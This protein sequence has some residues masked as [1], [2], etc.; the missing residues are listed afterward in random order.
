MYPSRSHFRCHPS[1]STG[2]RQ[3]LT[4]GHL[5]AA[6]ISSFGL[7]AGDFRPYSLT[8]LSGDGS[9]GRHCRGAISC[10]AAAVADSTVFDRRLLPND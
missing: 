6:P 10:R 4:I 2:A 9:T 1:G 5:A 8:A 3:P 7:H